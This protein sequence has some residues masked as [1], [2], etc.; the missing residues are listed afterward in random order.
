MGNLQPHI[1]FSEEEAAK[2]AILPGDPKRVDRIAKF[3]DDV[4][5][6]T[7]NREPHRRRLQ[8]QPPPQLGGIC[9]RGE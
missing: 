4:K 9:G 3:L 6:I 1:R 8:R 2:Y 5:E 7:F